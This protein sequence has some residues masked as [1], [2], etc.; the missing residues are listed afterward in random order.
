MILPSFACLAGFEFMK[1]LKYDSTF[2]YWAKTQ[3]K[4]VHKVP[5]SK[6][7]QRRDWKKYLYSFVPPST[8]ELGNGYCW[9]MASQKMSQQMPLD[10]KKITELS[11]P[12]NQTRLLV[13]PEIQV[14][15]S[16]PRGAILKTRAMVLVPELRSVCNA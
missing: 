13:Q 10:S 4:K 2:K 5:A 16:S 6:H 8:L 1:I 3:M 15:S 7:V 11:I 14:P 12:K 9:M